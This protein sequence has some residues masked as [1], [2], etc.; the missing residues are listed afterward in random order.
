MHALG[1]VLVGMLREGR[2]VPAPHGEP[3][4]VEPTSSGPT[5]SASS[6]ANRRAAPSP[7]CRSTASRI[8]RDQ[9]LLDTLY[10]TQG[11][12]RHIPDRPPHRMR[13]GR[14]VRAPREAESAP[15][16]LAGQSIIRAPVRGSMPCPSWV[17]HLKVRPHHVAEV[18]A[19]R[20]HAVEPRDEKIAREPFDERSHGIVAG[21]G[22]LAPRPDGVLTRSQLDARRDR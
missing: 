9:P 5:G 6:G 3:G 22:T 17:V 18:D 16:L 21:L 19:G 13:P 10:P 7:S 4:G 2:R 12:L 8:A 14:S 1:A 15:I 11:D 20:L